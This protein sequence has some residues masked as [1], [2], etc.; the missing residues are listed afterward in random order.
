[1]KAIGTKHTTYMYPELSLFITSTSEGR[2]GMLSVFGVIIC[3][4]KTADPLPFSP[5]ASYSFSQDR[6]ERVIAIVPSAASRCQSTR[7]T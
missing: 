7:A 6:N 5:A 2:Q 1:M 4:V 3:P